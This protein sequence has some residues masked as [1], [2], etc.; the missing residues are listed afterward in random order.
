MT[1]T[2]GEWGWQLVLNGILILSS[3]FSLLHGARICCGVRC[4]NR[5]A[6]MEVM[7]DSLYIALP[8]NH[9]IEKPD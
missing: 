6:K 7:D 4:G 2:W 3:P 1:M 8:L 9:Q 5:T